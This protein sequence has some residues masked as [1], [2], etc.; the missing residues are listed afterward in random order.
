MRQG[1]ALLILLALL[2][3][4]PSALPD[5]Q[6]YKAALPADVAR[7]IERLE[8]CEHF[9][10]EPPYDAERA[11]F[12]QRNIEELCPGND[13]TLAAMRRKYAGNPAVIERL[14]D[15]AAAYE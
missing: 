4:S 9:S 14:D 2:A 10:G 12:L 1:F 3:C 8:G 11:A 7:F 15:F 13:V 5:A 6:P